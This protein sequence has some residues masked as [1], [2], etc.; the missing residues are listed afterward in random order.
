MSWFGKRLAWIVMG[1][2]VL[3]QPVLAGGKVIAVLGDSLTAGYGLPQGEGLVPQ[4]QGWLDAQDAGVKLV[5]AGVSGDTTAG[6]LA[7]LD[8]TLGPDVQ[9]LVVELGAN[10]MLRGL[11]PGEARAN[12][13]KIV[14]A[15]KSK[16][17]P[18]LL[19]GFRAPANWGPDYKTAF[20]AIYPDLAAKEG[21]L[22]MPEFFG[23]LSPDG[24][25]AA[26][27]RYLQADGAHPTKE[28]VG[29]IVK[30]MGPW[31]LKLAGQIG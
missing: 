10:D 16:G 13:T 29:L 24:S 17:L 30:K 18:V 28:G 11:P 5:N 3:G 15:A 1:L 26:A 27:V 21:V 2:L 7:R 19:I 8:W 14:K 4:L 23:A 6:G 25:T 20:D 31:V 9:G 12:L 22:L